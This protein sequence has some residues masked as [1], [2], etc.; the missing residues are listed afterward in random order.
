MLLLL[1]CCSLFA[2]VI[3]IWWGLPSLQ[4]WAADEILPSQVD[5]TRAWSDKYP[6]LHRAVLRLAYFPIDLP[7]D[8]EISEDNWQRSYA[9]KFLTARSLSVLMALMT[10]YLV[11]RC[12]LLLAQRKEALLAA[13]A[14]ATMPAFGYYAKTANLEIP[15]LFWF[16]L[17]LLFFLRAATKRQMA[18]YIGFAAA[19][20]AA[21]ATKDQAYGLLIFPALFL[22]LDLLAHR[23]NSRQRSEPRSFSAFAKRLLVPC[24]V[25]IA[26]YALFSGFLFNPEQFRRHVQVITGPGTFRYQ[27]YGADMGGRMDL[28][29]QALRHTLFSLSLP[30]ALAVVFGLFVVL[31]RPKRNVLFLALVATALTYFFAFVWV[32]GYHY[33]RFFLPVG[34]LLSFLSARGM[35]EFMRIRRIP[36][37]LPQLC[38]AGVL[39]FAAARSLAVDVAMLKDSRYRI[40][41]W[42]ATRAAPDQTVGL[43]R[44]TMLPR[45]LTVLDWG[46]WPAQPCAFTAELPA[47]YLVV[48]NEDVRS[49]SEAEALAALNR[50]QTNYDEVFRYKAQSPLRLLGLNRVFSNLDKINPEIAVFER[51]DRPCVDATTMLPLLARSRGQDRA[52]VRERLLE[53]A[54][55]FPIGDKKALVPEA[56]YALGLRYDN[57]TRGNHPAAVAMRNPGPKPAAVDLRV[58]CLAGDQDLPIRLTVDVG[59][60]RRE[61]RFNTRGEKTIRLAELAPGEE[62]L[63]LLWTDKSWLYQ[64]RG[65]RRLGVSILTAALAP[66]EGPAKFD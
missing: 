40:E 9:L 62:R 27:L 7:A 53:A 21:V 4:G 56:V 54:F 15:Y 42:L 20:A 45:R 65:T 50:G 26:A 14:T 19:G 51:S 38:V 57:W 33:V 60:K 59:A 48:N 32:V 23:S 64:G 30:L 28:V 39:A 35:T 61:V 55:S 10:V 12:G 41:S 13:T 63:A 5:G 36:K 29:F 58:G 44:K 66:V 2:N 31:R 16:T 17:S 34:L 37:P 22:V 6:P 46:H 52:T 1:L 18:D 25:G 43:G 3:P 8:K 49:R 11:Y 24:T 47:K